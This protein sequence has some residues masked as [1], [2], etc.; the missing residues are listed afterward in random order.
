[1]RIRK[2]TAIYAAVVVTCFLF[3]VYV[4]GL[5]EFGEYLYIGAINLPAS[6]LLFPIAEKILSAPAEQAWFVLLAS[7]GV[8]SGLLA[9]T[10]AIVRG[11][12][13]RRAD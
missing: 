5:R 4:L 9:G 1:M 8:N 2:I 3:G 7:I 12:W 6:L 10:I 13:L 11:A